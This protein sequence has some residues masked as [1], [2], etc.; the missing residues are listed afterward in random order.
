M[1]PSIYSSSRL[2]YLAFAALDELLL[3]LVYKF[4]GGF[5]YEVL[6]AKDSNSFEFSNNL[7]EFSDNIFMIYTNW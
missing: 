4:A 1:D 7:L 2:Y 3:I 5:W 6:M